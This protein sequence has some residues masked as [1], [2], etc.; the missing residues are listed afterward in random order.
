MSLRKKECLGVAKI[1]IAN[2]FDEL[3]EMDFVDYG[4]YATFFAHSI[5]FCAFLC[6][7]FLG[8]KKKEEQTAEMAKESA[9]SERISFFA[10]PGIMGIMMVGK[11]S[12]FIGGISPRLLYIS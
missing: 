3:V 12:R 4:D 11:D 8:A 2:T 5:Y 10:T 7:Y 1:L 6:H 9:I